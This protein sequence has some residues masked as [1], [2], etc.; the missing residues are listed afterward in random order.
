MRLDRIHGCLAGLAL[1]DALGM[2]TEMLTPEQ[3]TS[4]FGWVDHLVLAP[5]WHP[6]KVF[7]S[8]RVTDD[9]GQALA[10]AHSFSPEGLLSA[11][12]VSDGLLAWADAVGEDLPI[13]AGPSTRRALERLRV[14]EDPHHTGREGTTNGAAYRA[15]PIGLVNFDHQ[16]LCQEQVVEACL[17]THGTSQAIS[18]AMAIALAV[19]KALEEGSTLE[20]IQQAG[21]QGAV[22]GRNQG[23]WTWGTQLEKRIDLALRLIKENPKPGSALKALYDF[24]G[25]DILVA[26]SVATA[27]GIVDLAQGDPMKAIIYGANI[28]GDTDTIAALAGAICGAW[29]GIEAFDRHML[30]Q[31]EEINHLDLTAEAIHLETIIQ[32][33][34]A[35]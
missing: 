18:G 9:T 5:T 33:R 11:N 28:G 34:R 17:P 19:A 21:R 6:H 31:V 30:A 13:I 4:E 16:E 22:V 27:F 29:R 3:I 12:A 24:V 14:G 7:A 20:M 2:P 10:I 35:I 26:E 8:G 15:I 1:G 25:V 23:V 32:K